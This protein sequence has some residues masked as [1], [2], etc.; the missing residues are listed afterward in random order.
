[1]T[2]FNIKKAATLTILFIQFSS[3][4]FFFQN[5]SK[6]NFSKELPIEMASKTEP[7]VPTVYEPPVS[8]AGPVHGD[9]I[10]FLKPFTIEEQ[11]I[12]PKTKILI[13]VDNS[14]SMQNSQKNLAKGLDSISLSLQ[15]QIADGLNPEV[16]FYIVTTTIPEANP[17]SLDF[18]DTSGKIS[19]Q[20][21]N[22]QSATL[23]KFILKS[24]NSVERNI[25]F[26]DIQNIAKS[27]D[28][29]LQPVP[30]P[31][32]GYYDTTTPAK[33]LA[34]L[35]ASPL[36]KSYQNFLGFDLNKDLSIT[37]E[38]VVPK[39]VHKDGT[40]LRYTANFDL[41]TNYPGKQQNG[42]FVPFVKVSLNSLRY[43]T[44]PNSADRQFDSTKFA[45][46]REE[47]KNKITAV[48]T[49]GSNKEM[50]LCALH[51]SLTM[52][53]ENQIFSKNDRAAFLIISDEQDAQTKWEDCPL[54]N[55]IGSDI[56][57]YNTVNFACKAGENCLFPAKKY[58]YYG[59]LN[60]EQTVPADNNPKQV[61]VY[62][63]GSFT[64]V[65]N[66]ISSSYVSTGRYYLRY[67]SFS[68]AK[69]YTYM[70]NSEGQLTTVP[71]DGKNGRALTF[72]WKTERLDF[73]DIYFYLISDYTT[74]TA[75]S[76]SEASAITK[77]NNKCRPEDLAAAL[78]GTL[79]LNPAFAAFYNSL[80]D[81]NKLLAFRCDTAIPDTE[82]KYV[83]VPT[84]T[85]NNNFFATTLY[86]LTRTVSNDECKVIKS[87]NS[88][89][90]S[91][92]VKVKDAVC[93][94][95]DISSICTKYVLDSCQET[96]TPGLP[97]Y[98][99]KLNKPMIFKSQDPDFITNFKPGYN[100]PFQSR[101]LIISQIRDSN[102]ITYSS[103]DDFVA[104]NQDKLNI[105]FTGITKQPD[106]AVGSRSIST[107][108]NFLPF[109]KMTDISARMTSEGF[110][111][112]A[113]ANTD[114]KTVKEQIV[115]SFHM[116]AK[117]LFNN[118][119][120]ISSI[121]IPNDNSYPTGR[122]PGVPDQ[123][124]QSPGSDYLTLLDD[125][126][127]T[128]IIQVNGQQIT[129]V[130]SDRKA[131]ADICKEDF[132]AALEPLKKFI[133]KVAKNRYQITVP[134]GREIHSIETL[135]NGKKK[136]LSVNDWFF[137]GKEIIFNQDAIGIGDDIN[138]NLT[139]PAEKHL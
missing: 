2:R 49:S 127:F 78:K 72:D 87:R 3:I 122:C 30:L 63:S 44:N 119:Y 28:I 89:F 103:Y 100:L 124:S 135:H 115:S 20:F 110:N 101:N 128:K 120:F 113:A 1:M 53:G 81:E 27:G 95:G 41:N 132:S 73:R 5:C 48:T 82:T 88:C 47:L 12:V 67:L 56:P 125:I 33:N 105:S 52:D 75:F 8:P 43:L 90:D 84:T 17:S 24:P 71:Y 54:Q 26:D 62:A 83:A 29:L 107:I 61:S 131:F 108:T 76:S 70:N 59:T 45:N 37:S 129:E 104:K 4:L 138:V 77:N 10:G 38:N 35:K 121:V 69:D 97:E 6:V 114:L 112:V 86:T 92:L 46:F 116:R 51:R 137:D 93:P 130:D 50:G 21:T 15:N 102:F 126:Y 25:T 98:I 136:V 39:Y 65:N 9:I 96:C 68:Y 34:A 99:S 74:Q 117:K 64:K 11:K 111:F 133:S 7:L 42:S 13:V 60:Y 22:S 23:K 14:G 85:T 139:I 94:P 40:P 58:D 31:L 36:Y 19:A 55:E 66:Y 18:I 79:S 118:N 134:V 109:I 80:S 123:E 106:P 57:S 32:N 91:T 16:D